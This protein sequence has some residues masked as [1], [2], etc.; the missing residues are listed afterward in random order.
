MSGVLPLLLPP[1]LSSVKVLGSYK[2]SPDAVQI[3]QTAATGDTALCSFVAQVISFGENL[4][5]HFTP[6]EYY[7]LFTESPVESTSAQSAEKCCWWLSPEL[8]S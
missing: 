8:L 6:Y 2:P 5:T 3:V 1:A 7:I 4:F